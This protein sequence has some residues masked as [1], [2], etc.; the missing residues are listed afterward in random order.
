V[1]KI[2]RVLQEA[3]KIRTKAWKRLQIVNKGVTM[4]PSQ[5]PMYSF[6]VQGERGDGVVFTVPVLIRKDKIDL[7]PPKEIVR[8]TGELIAAKVQMLM[9]F[10]GCECTSETECA[11]HNTKVSV[12]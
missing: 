7:A 4:D 9:T 2:N 1:S 8:V 6:T 12:H 3:Q 10:T 5:P 11:E